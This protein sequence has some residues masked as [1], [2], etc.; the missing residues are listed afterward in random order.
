MNSLRVI[1]PYLTEQGI[2]VFDDEAVGLVREPFIKGIPEMIH[3]F[4][5]AAGIKNAIQGFALLFSEHPFPGNQACL[6]W[7]REEYGGNWYRARAGDEVIEGWLC[8][9][10]LQYFPTA[11]KRLFIECKPIERS[12]H[13]QRF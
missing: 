9:A 7:V 12:S 6:E 13:V 5:E 4:T 10:L 1:F 8:P 2:W 11:P 3:Y